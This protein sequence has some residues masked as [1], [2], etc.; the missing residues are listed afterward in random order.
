MKPFW[1]AS[2]AGRALILGRLDRPRKRLVMMVEVNILVAV[3]G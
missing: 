3:G 2:V 1:V